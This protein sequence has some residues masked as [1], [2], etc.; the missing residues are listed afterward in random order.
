LE[1]GLSSS[2]PLTGAEN[3]AHRRIVNNRIK[4]LKDIDEDLTQI[5]VHPWFYLC[6]KNRFPA[7]EGKHDTRVF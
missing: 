6:N 3:A 7:W 5:V 1:L 2:I 4:L